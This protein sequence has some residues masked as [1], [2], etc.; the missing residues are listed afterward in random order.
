MLV[1]QIEHPVQSFDEW[2]KVFDSDPI[3]RKKSGVMRYRIFRLAD[4]PAYVIVDLEFQEIE[5]LNGTLAA[6]QKVWGAVEG[7][8]IMGPKS[9]I[10]QVVEEREL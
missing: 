9:R 7:K 1:L 5:K 3:E 6:L 4:N 10:L 2:K 8:V